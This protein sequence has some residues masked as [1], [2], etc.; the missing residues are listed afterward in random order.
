MRAICKDA[1][2]IV[3]LK[4]AQLLLD[5][6][7]NAHV[8]IRPADWWEKK[9]S[10]HFGKLYRL[11]VARSSRACFKTWNRN[12]IETL[13]YYTLRIQYNLVYYIFRI[14]GKRRY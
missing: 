11:K 12:P 2:I 13:M 1:L 5:D 6:G 7:R 3:D 8:T 10:K 4:E 9:I 14:F